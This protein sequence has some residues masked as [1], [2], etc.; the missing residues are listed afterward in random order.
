M[1]EVQTRTNLFHPLN[2]HALKGNEH[3]TLRI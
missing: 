3:Q 1:Q 2:L